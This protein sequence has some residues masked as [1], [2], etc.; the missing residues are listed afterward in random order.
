M[1]T[2]IIS[3]LVENQHGALSRVAGL[4]SSRGYNISSLNVAETDDPTVSRM[5]IVV[6]GEESILEQVVKQLNR[7]IDVIKVIDYADKSLLID[8]ELLLLRVDAAKSNRHEIIE[9]ADVFGA[10]VAAVSPRS[11]SIELTH[12][13]DMLEDFIGMLKPY[14]I[15][16]LVRSGKIALARSKP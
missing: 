10:K 1:S 16:E 15:K 11:I 13:S 5:T 7:L 3:L 4:F 8:R 12:T 9:L 6:A 14:G 2:H